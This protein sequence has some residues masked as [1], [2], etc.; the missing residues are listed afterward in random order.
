MNILNSATVHI[1]DDDD[2]VRDSFR[3]LLESHGLTV[4]DY[5]SG[6]DFLADG[7]QQKDGCLLLDLHMPGM[8]GLQ[9]L[10][11]LREDRSRLPVI[12]ITGRIDSTLKRQIAQAGAFALLEKPMDDEV[13]MWTIE[14]AIAAR[15]PVA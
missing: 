8:T 15:L 1:V 3:S 5:A 14:N 9:L 13:L 10:E 2:A 12:A 11:K 7:Q 4:Q 6:D